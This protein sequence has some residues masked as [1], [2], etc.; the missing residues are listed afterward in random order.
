M[1]KPINLKD[2]PDYLKNIKENNS[3]GENVVVDMGNIVVEPAGKN[4]FSFLAI[5]LLFILFFGGLTAYNF[6]LKNTETIIL[7]SSNKEDIKTISD[8]LINNGVK[9]VSI[10][11][12]EDDTFEIKFNK[13]KDL[14]SFLEN[15]RK[16]KQLK[17][18]ELKN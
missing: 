9:I 1:T 15:L 11:Q 5:G 3:Y 6:S 12:K 18:I 17:K 8:I 2:L 10:K 7:S 4:Y 16:N 13:L 14:N